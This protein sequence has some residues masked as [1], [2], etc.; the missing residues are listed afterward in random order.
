MQYLK[1]KAKKKVKQKINKKRLKKKQYYDGYCITVLVCYT[2]YAGYFITGIKIHFRM[3][4]TT[5]VRGNRRK[6]RIH[7]RTVLWQP[8]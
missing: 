3:S 4:Y 1:K 7:T 8:S 6:I 2:Y 5:T